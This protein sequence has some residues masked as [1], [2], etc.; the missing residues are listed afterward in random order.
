[1]PLTVT[2]YFAR[3]YVR[4]RVRTTVQS[5]GVGSRASTGLAPGEVSIGVLRRGDAV[6]DRNRSC[7]APACD[8]AAAVAPEM[9]PPQLP[10]LLVVHLGR[11]SAWGN[12]N[13]LS[14]WQALGRATGAEVRTIDLA[15]R[16]SRPGDLRRVHRLARGRIVPEALYWS[17]AKL[18]TELLRAATVVFVTARTFDPALLPPG[19]LV[20]LDY[21]DRL[22]ESYRQRAELTTRSRRVLYGALG[23][24]MRRFE[25]MPRPSVR[26]VAAGRADAEQLGASWLPNLVI[27]LPPRATPAVRSDLLFH[28]NLSY[29]PN[30]QAVRHL[31]VL[32]PSLRN[33]RPGITIT[34]AGANPSTDLAQKI[35]RTP[36]WSLQR[37]F[38]DL[39]LILASAR[40][41]VA[42]LLSAT[43]LQNK[44]LESA[45]A[46][47]P[48]V[49]SPAVARGFDP[50]FPLVVADSPHD[51]VQSLTSLLDDPCARGRMG[52]AARDHVG[53]YYTVMAWRDLAAQLLGWPRSCMPESVS[54]WQ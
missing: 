29:P 19:A 10:Q 37:D 18:R 3:L 44:V 33:V 36:G 46:G 8:R 15:Q 40:I 47:L 49:V 42:P 50:N 14:T 35:A 17:G 26:A 52:A 39:S 27:E 11:S 6:L 48:T 9:G 43:G 41:S 45:S 13:R 54:D 20:V 31:L 16:R 53:K 12:R 51:W 23:V 28:G 24:Q 38:S 22:S 4:R 21:V 1:V 30:V 5:T 32:W 7:R 25:Q 34:V 2:N